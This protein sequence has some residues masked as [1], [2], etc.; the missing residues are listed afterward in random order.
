[1]AKHELT[2][3][4]LVAFNIGIQR[5]DFSTK[6]VVSSQHRKRER[7]MQDKSKGEISKLD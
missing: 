2:M 1:M 7:E 3:S 6:V 4:L 5:A